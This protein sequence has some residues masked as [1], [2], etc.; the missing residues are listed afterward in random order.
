MK[1][2]SWNVNGLRAVLRKNFLEYLDSESPD[3]LCLQET[4]ASHDDVER[5]WPRGYTTDWNTARRKGYSG[6]AIFTTPSGGGN[7]RV[8]EKCFWGGP[9]YTSGESR[10][11]GSLTVLFTGVFPL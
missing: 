10:T 11:T 9:H 5:L 8:F 4:K 6:T 1:L 3:I 2:V 7:L